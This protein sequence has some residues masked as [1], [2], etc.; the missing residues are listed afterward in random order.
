MQEE[1]NTLINIIFVSILL[2]VLLLAVVLII[3]ALNSGSSQ[4]G[5]LSGNTVDSFLSVSP[6]QSLT[7]SASSLINSKCT[8]SSVSDNFGVIDL[9]NYTATN[10][11]VTYN[12]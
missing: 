3:G 11:I 12:P 6:G 2:V 5:Q 1:S 10:C 9:S 4:K 7:L 8:V